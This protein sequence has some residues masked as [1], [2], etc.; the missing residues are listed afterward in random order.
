[1]VHVCLKAKGLLIV[2]IKAVCYLDTLH[3]CALQSVLVP[4][5]V[6]MSYVCVSSP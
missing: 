1:M 3:A 6:L 5:I 2:R 4:S